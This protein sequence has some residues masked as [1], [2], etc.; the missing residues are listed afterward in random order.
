MLDG[1]LHGEGEGEHIRCS[2]VHIATQWSGSGGTAAFVK[3]FRPLVPISVSVATAMCCKV[4]KIFGR[5]ALTN[6]D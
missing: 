3:L 6:A 5:D 2:L 1:V 4:S